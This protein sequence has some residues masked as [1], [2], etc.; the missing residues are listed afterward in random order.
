MRYFIEQYEIRAPK[1]VCNFYS[2]CSSGNR[3]R[4]DLS[5]AKNTSSPSA[6]PRVGRRKRKS[7]KRDL[8]NVVLVFTRR[9]TADTVAPLGQSNLGGFKAGLY[10][11]L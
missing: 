6:K 2:L 7:L 9:P 3:D 5:A 11:Q 10:Y 4:S 8:F 1:Q